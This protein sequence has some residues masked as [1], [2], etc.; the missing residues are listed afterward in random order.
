MKKLSL[1]AAIFVLGFFVAAIGFAQE[2]VKKHPSCKYCGMDREKFAH[3]R[4][5][6]EYEDGTTEG[7]CSLRCA[8]V[9][10]TVNLDK[11][12]KAIRVGDYGTKNLI[13]AEKA[14]WV[15]GGSKMGVMTKRAKW[16]FEKKEDAEKFTK[17][18]GGDLATFEQ[19]IKA[20]YEDMYQDT[21]MIRERRKMR[22]MEKK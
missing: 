3:S 8:A 21:K 13:D 15:I 9:D 4:V 17:E 19:A 20:T 7:M 22:K 18:N 16:A 5:L 12:P 6:V 2:D 14:F 1:C 11:T 10:L